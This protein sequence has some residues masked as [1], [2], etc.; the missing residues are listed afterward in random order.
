MCTKILPYS[1]IRK[2]SNTFLKAM[3]SFWHFPLT[4]KTVLS[5]CQTNA[6]K[7]AML[8]P[9][10]GLL[11]FFEFSGDS[12]NTLWNDRTAFTCLLSMYWLDTAAVNSSFSRKAVHNH[13]LAL[14]ILTD[15]LEVNEYKL[16]Y[17]NCKTS[18]FQSKHFCSTDETILFRPSNNIVSRSKHKCL[19]SQTILFRRINIRFCPYFWIS[20]RSVS[21]EYS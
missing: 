5:I 4:W 20:M 3:L 6:L 7:T 18:L 14:C 10:Y 17:K 16:M 2:L 9:K 19:T 12:Q 15:K 8:A 13:T 21:H 11:D 1:Y